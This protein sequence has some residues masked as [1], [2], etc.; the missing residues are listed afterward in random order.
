MSR[1]SVDEV[2]DGLSD[3]PGAVVMLLDT[4]FCLAVAAASGR[5]VSCPT[6]DRPNVGIV[7]L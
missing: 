6:G 5:A 3:L 7:D 4:L 2:E 1:L